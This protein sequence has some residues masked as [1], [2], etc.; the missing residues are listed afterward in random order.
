[1][2]HTV[3]GIAGIALNPNRT[4]PDLRERLLAMREAMVKR[5]VF[6]SSSSVYGNSPTLPKRE[7]MPTNPLL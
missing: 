6:A 3:C 4:L 1:M 5:V 2:I 7:D